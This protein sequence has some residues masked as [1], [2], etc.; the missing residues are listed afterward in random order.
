MTK[1][2]IERIVDASF[3]SALNEIQPSV[4]RELYPAAFANEYSWLR[5]KSVFDLQNRAMCT[6]VKNALSE[7]LGD[8]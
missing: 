6:A 4:N 3:K 8:E 1:S 5:V 7:I 2:E